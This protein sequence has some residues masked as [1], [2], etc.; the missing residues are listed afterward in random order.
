MVNTNNS[1]NAQPIEISFDDSKNSTDIDIDYNI[2]SQTAPTKPSKSRKCEC[3]TR[4]ILKFWEIGKCAK[5]QDRFG[6]EYQ[7]QQREKYKEKHGRYPEPKDPNYYVKY[8]EK[9]SEKILERRA[10]K[11]AQHKAEQEAL[12]SFK[13]V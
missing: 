9:N 6:K 8:Y 13:Q 10:I 4:L 12:N 2:N 11:R 7:R 1:N 5:C 3:G